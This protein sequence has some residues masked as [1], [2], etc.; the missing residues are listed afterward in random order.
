MTT[1]SKYTTLHLELLA[2]SASRAP[3]VTVD[4]LRRVGLT[5]GPRA[6]F[7]DVV[8]AVADEATGRDAVVGH[9]LSL[10][11]ARGDLSAAILVAL[12][13][14]LLGFTNRIGGRSGAT[15]D[16]QADVLAAAWTAIAE[17][18]G[19]LEP[20]PVRLIQRAWDLSRA[21]VRWR[22]DRSMREVPRNVCEI[23]DMRA[24]QVVEEHVQGTLLEAAIRS[25]AISVS[26]AELI[27]LTRVSGVTLAELS[28]SM[29]IPR[30][31]LA[32]RRTSAERALR[33]MSR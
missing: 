14:T 17:E 25:G 7:E 11:R 21:R 19:R 5:I 33:R 32:A 30:T 15:E 23:L 13:P 29:S 24:A 22:R 2:L 27:E 1:K 26:D 9:L 18:V 16:E 10:G 31:T 6:T 8:D 12:H 20:D 4:R 3:R 28:R